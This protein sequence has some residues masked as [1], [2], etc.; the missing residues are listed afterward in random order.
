[1]LLYDVPS[2]TGT[3]LALDTIVALSRL[4]NIAGIKDASGDLARA[5]RLRY[6]V[7]PDFLRLS[8]DDAS[9]AA[10]LSLGG[11]GC[12]SVTANVAPALCAAMHRA[13]AARDRHRF[14]RIDA[15]LQ[16]INAALFIETNPIP[17]KWALARLGL[18]EGELRLPLT[19]LSE[20]CVR[21]VLSALD[22]V[23]AAEARAEADQNCFAA[24]A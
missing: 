19:P 17:V 14:E 7:G 23:V 4:P 5:G 24:V 22:S 11:H 16:D 20:H 21:P 13:W 8:G 10:H 3:A 18:I 9:L 2:R 1:V 6:S 12:I 15:L